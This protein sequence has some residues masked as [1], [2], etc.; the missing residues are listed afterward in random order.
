VRA[1]VK[2]EDAM[3]N[4]IFVVRLKSGFASIHSIM[5]ERLEMHEEHLVLVSAS[6]RLA[7]LFLTE[8]VEGITQL[9]APLEPQLKKPA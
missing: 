1:G 9:P 2:A 6:G 4:R 5:A 8:H 7:A 3:S